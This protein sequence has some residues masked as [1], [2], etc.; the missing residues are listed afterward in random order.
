MEGAVDALAA[1]LA[2][3]EN[4]KQ[5]FAI[6]PP[7]YE[8]ARKAKL[9]ALAR[10]PSSTQARK[11]VRE[12]RQV[13]AY[14]LRTDGYVPT[15]TGTYREAYDTTEGRRFVAFVRLEMYKDTIDKLVAHYNKQVKALG[16]TFV[17]MFPLVGW[18]YPIDHGTIV[19]ALEAGPFKDIG[20]AERYIIQTIDGR[21]PAGIDSFAKI[22]TD[23]HARLE[24]KGG[25]FRM[26]VMTGDGTAKREFS[27][28]L[29]GPIQIENGTTTPTK[30]PTGNGNGRPDP[31]T[32]G[33]VNVW[34]RYGGNKGSG[35]DDPTQ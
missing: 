21:D 28:E 2:R 19:F 34:D 30:R 18:R 4:D 7:I 17:P 5:W 15:G 32:P 16:G 1:E 29:K 11:D 3:R 8:S 9:A 27:T 14:R 26:D 12:A 6:V 23:T 35:R 25:T 20:L 10:D 22:A 33:G 31:A 24:D 13:S